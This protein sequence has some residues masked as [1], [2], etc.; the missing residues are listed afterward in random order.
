MPDQLPPDPLMSADGRNRPADARCS[1]LA[2]D[3]VSV[4]DEAVWSELDLCVLGERRQGGPVGRVDPGVERLRRER[5]IHRA[6][7]EMGEPQRARDATSDRALARAG[8]AVDRD[9]ERTAVDRPLGAFGCGH[10]PRVRRGVGG[11]ARSR[12][13][14]GDRLP[15]GDHR[16]SLSGQGGHGERHRDPMVP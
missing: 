16:L 14:D 10:R 11:L 7:V 5:A 4:D 6:R 9:D 3:G 13:R 2:P 12:V 8:R 1:G 15:P